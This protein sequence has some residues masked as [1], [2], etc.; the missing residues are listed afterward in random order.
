MTFGGE[1]ALDGMTLTVEPGEVHGLL[2]E[3]GCGKSTVIKILAGFH[4]PDSGELE[5][6]GTSVPLPLRPGQFR[7]LGMSFVHQDLGLVQSLSVLDNM[8]V[9]DFATSGGWR[10][11]WRSER[12]A[13]RE[14]FAKYGLKIPLD[15]K[16][17]ELSSVERALIA[18][19]RAAE[20][21]LGRLDSAQGGGALLILD[22]PTVFL[23]RA[24]VDALFTLVR[25]V[26]DLGASVLFVSHD[27]DEVCEITDRVTVMRDGR[28]VGTRVTADTTDQDLVEMI[29]GRRLA[30]RA[31]ER[32]PAPR[33]DHVKVEQLSGSGVH[34]VSFALGRGEIVGIT[35]LLGSG[36][37]FVPY[38]LFGALQATSGTLT[39][40]PTAK[41][42]TGL[43]PNAAL[44]AGIALL[45]ADRGRLGAVGSIPVLDNV[46]L[47]VLPSYFTKGRLRRRGMLA[48]TSEL[49][50]EADVRP[51]DPTAR[52]SSLSGGNQQKALLA[53]WLQVPL[54]LLLLHEPT[55]GVDVGAREQIVS[56][57]R[58]KA[59]AGLSVLCSSSDYGQLAS[60]C[61]RVLVFGRGRIVDELSDR[62]FD[63]EA[64]SE[65]C[66]RTTTERAV[67]GS[68]QA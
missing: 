44:E 61:D 23:P 34:D 17:F 54:E 57:I 51:R 15:A 45:P 11:S 68:V 27:L 66:Y 56:I 4:A 43:T 9:W 40:G 58:A 26:R 63:K 55:Q 30:A 36:F 7:A 53:K 32:D 33:D 3:N 6:N 29:V 38:L 20:D 62:D 35:G 60:L 14:T 21:M 8:K 5:V 46:A 31:V 24:E 42:V 13:V 12:A 22:E 52:F 10:I 65:S 49:L 48:R 64:I 67:P 28:A 19:A 16:I 25:R 39:I 18:I 50:D 37:E 59:R 2:G 47:P 41:D 1:R